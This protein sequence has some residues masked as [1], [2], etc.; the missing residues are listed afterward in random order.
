MSEQLTNFVLDGSSISLHSLIR[1]VG[2]G[3]NMQ[4]FA[5]E[6]LIILS[7]V[8]SETCVNAVI[9]GWTVGG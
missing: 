4:D 1:N 9:F 6:F 2:H 7:T 3:S 5:G 8:S